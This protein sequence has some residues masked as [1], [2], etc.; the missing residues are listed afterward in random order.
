MIFFSFF[1]FGWL[2]V[3]SS[4]DFIEAFKKVVEVCK[5]LLAFVKMY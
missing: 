3:V 4:V 1:S 2:E 5:R